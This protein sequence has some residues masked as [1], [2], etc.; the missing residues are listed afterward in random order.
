MQGFFENLEDRR[1]MSTTYYV[2]VGGSDSGA[3]S[4]AAPLAT[5]QAAANKVV[6]GD[7]VIVGAGT[8][9]GFILSMTMRSRARPLPPSHSKPIP[10]PPRAA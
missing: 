3:G 4:K 6:A 2:S 5:I 10:T 1:L 7:T 9:A 8:Y